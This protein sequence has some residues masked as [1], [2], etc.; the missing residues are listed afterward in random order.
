[1]E[2][3]PS[4]LNTPCIEKIAAIAKAMPEI[5]KTGI[6]LLNADVLSEVD[7]ICREVP[8]TASATM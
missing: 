8:T 4:L 7:L 6:Y 5:A 1:M 2:E 3:I